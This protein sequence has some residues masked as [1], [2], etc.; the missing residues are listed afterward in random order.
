MKGVSAGQYR[1]TGRN[2]TRRE[3]ADKRMRRGWKQSVRFCRQAGHQSD[4]QRG[5]VVQQE[6]PGTSRCGDN[7]VAARGRV[8]FDT[9]IG[10]YHLERHRVGH[11]QQ[12]DVAVHDRE[13]ASMCAHS[14]Y[15]R[16]C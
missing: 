13:R 2:R 10:L 15:V 16:A 5:S 3:G 9:R 4:C 12:A 6:G 14:A 7:L 8:A 11:L 1:K